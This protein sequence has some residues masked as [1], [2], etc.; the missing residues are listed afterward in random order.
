MLKVGKLYLCKEYFLLLYP[1]RET[2]IGAARPDGAA[3]EAATTA[4][5]ADLSSSAAAVRYCDPETPLLVLNA[6]NEYAEALVGDQKAWIINREWLKI[7][8]IV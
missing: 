3:A 1:D 4:A 2:A 6:D 7:E 5:A 8:E